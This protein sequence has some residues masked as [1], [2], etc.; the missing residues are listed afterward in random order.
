MIFLQ[1][2]K[3][4]I[5]NNPKLFPVISILIGLFSGGIVLLLAGYNP[6][7]AYGIILWGIFGKVSY[8][9]YTIVKA[10]PL[11]LTGLSVAFAFRTGLFNIGAEGQFIMGSIVAAVFGSLFSMPFYLHIPFIILLTIVITGLFG[12]VLGYLKARFGVHEVISSIMMNWV[13]LY[14]RN[15]FVR[16]SW[17]A[18]PNS[19]QTVSI[20]D[21]AV[22]TFFDKFKM[23]SEGIQWLVAHPFCKGVLRAPVNAGIF[24]AILAV[25]LIFFVLEKTTLGYRLK[26]VGFNSDAA[27]FGG[28][29]VNKSFVT[30]MFIAGALSGLAGAL[31]VMA[32]SHNI[33]ILSMMEGY[34]FDGIAVALIG[35][36]TALGSLWAGVF[37]GALKYGGTKLQPLMG[38]PFEIIN[39]MM[40][41]IVFFVAMPKIIP[42]IISIFEKKGDKNVE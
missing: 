23:S 11:I 33:S 17:L 36:C 27:R 37:F 6:I 35:G 1:K 25:V 31:Q 19:E 42:Y 24:V 39:I 15:Y 9:S 29:D 4:F 13:A 10:T 14:L 2:F 32:V 28:I 22:I 38:A 5:N 26:A 21:S 7:E 30:S 40:G 8:F 16:L 3:Q 34:G 20:F 18:K 12:A 41:V